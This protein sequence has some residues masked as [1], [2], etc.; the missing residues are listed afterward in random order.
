M[1]SRLLQLPLNK[2]VVTGYRERVDAKFLHEGGILFHSDEAQSRGR[3]RLN[4]GQN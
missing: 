2:T 3:F 4:M 1:L